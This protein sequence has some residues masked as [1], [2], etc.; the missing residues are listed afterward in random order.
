MDK[1]SEILAARGKTHGKFEDHARVT[2]FLKA[3]HR[4]HQMRELTNTQREAL[5]MIFHKIGRIASG[6]PNVAD[7]WADIAGY[8]RLVADE[9]DSKSN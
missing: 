3:L 8:A 7:H 4:S 1:T 5:E 2:Q 6:D 9:L